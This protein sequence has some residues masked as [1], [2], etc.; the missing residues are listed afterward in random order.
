MST[1][2]SLVAHCPYCLAGMHPWPPI[3][4]SIRFLNGSDVGQVGLVVEDDWGTCPSDR[5]LVRMGYQKANNLR[6]VMPS[7]ELFLDVDLMVIPSWMPSVST[8]DNA[9][10]HNALLR[11][12]GFYSTASER[13][14]VGELTRH[15]IAAC[16]RRRL[17][18][19]GVDL[20]PLFMAH[21]VQVNIE[22]EFIEY[23]DFGISLLVATHGRKA[24][25]QKR[26][27]AMS[28][29]RYLTKAQRELH[30]D[31]FGHD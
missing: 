21:S 1:E 9:H 8:E 13:F 3:G 17:P 2:S 6:L 5:F 11:S 31:I 23:F 7:H 20:W 19:N 12:L 16:W 26:M 10:L 27:P 4:T 28:K 25:K 14:S 30:L 15:V 24:I 22:A 18:L 29:G